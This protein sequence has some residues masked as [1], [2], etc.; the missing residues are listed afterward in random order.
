MF[1]TLWRGGAF[2]AARS[3]QRWRRSRKVRLQLECLEDRAVPT[4][5]VTATTINNVF[6]GQPN[7]G[8]QAAT[9]T[10]SNTTL[11]ASQFHVTI[12]YGDGSTPVTNVIPAP[13]GTILDNNLI[14]TGSAGN[15]TVSDN[16]TFLEESGS[17]VPPFAFSVS[18]S[19]T[20]NIPTGLT[21]TGTGQAF[22]LDA[23][24][25]PGNPISAGTPARFTGGNAG[26]TTGAATALSNF[27]AAIGGTKNTGAPQSSGFRTITW[28][29][30]KVDGTDAAAGA[31]STVVITPGHTVGIPLDR[32]QGQGV[33]FGAIYAVTNDGFVDVNASV[34]GSN[35]VLFQAFS[36]PNTFAMFNDN[37]IDFKFVVPSSPF[38]P[39]V[40]AVS[41]GFGAI[42]LN[43]QQAGTTIQYFHGSTLLDTLSVPVTPTAGSTV[44]AG[45]LF[46]NAIVTN[47]LLTL[48]QGVIFKFDGTTVVG[49][50]ANSA[51]NN[52]VATDDFVYAEP[53]AAGN[54]FPI[55]SGAQGTVNAHATVN[56]TVGVPFTGIVATFSD[57]DP[58]GNAKDY[59]A[60]INWGDGHF[61]NGTLTMN[62][63]GGFDV[64]GTNTYSTPRNF[65]INV[66]IADF[67]GGP[68]PGGSQ[69]TLSVNNTA[70]VSAGDQNH[71]FV[72]QVYLDL[73][74][75]TV[76]PSGLQ[77]WG[78]GLAAGIMSRLQV[79]QGIENSLEYQ[80]IEVNSAYQQ[81]LGRQA[82]PGGLNG[83]VQFL[84]N[85]GTLEQLK[86]MLAGSLEFM[87]DAQ[88]QD[89]TPG[90]TT[91]NQKF[92][93][94][95]FQKVLN[96]TADS[97]GLTG[98]TGALA[99]GTPPVK[100]AFMVIVSQ[101][102]D[103]LLVN[104]LY[105]QFLKRPADSGG[106]NAFT[107]ALLNG[108]RDEA[109]IAGLVASNEYF[110]LV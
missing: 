23:A 70:H 32:F 95:L 36:T 104:G 76:D 31:N 75:R 63:Q 102:A 101:E 71:R 27:E 64:S 9:F 100:V 28:D 30:V 84:Q 85:G 41:R 78:G 97:G 18:I 66:D 68:G 73:L 51:T 62:S 72:A 54:G 20:E 86:A 65:P 52:L 19:V 67:G 26:N 11:T 80:V 12:N 57:S 81:I 108:V 17:T 34:G 110:G 5:A 91:A 96:R 77:F 87:N 74:G 42:F 89:T 88:T 49:G 47:V 99:N 29:G 98:F 56:P 105:P 94:F 6:E 92:V 53:Q 69:P 82:D 59:T 7:L 50:G 2:E 109:I 38:T 3:A 14:V 35:P 55:V 13:A 58:N 4:V 48:G 103:A 1:Q 44:F 93:D 16:H 33:F 90:L 107:Q 39:P 8:L 45:E 10:D 83:F 15:F 46:S 21:G 22:V 106:L 40:S 37:G 25:A 61:S 24:L 79:V 43:V 60:T